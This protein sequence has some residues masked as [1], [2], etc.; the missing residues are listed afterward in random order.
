MGFVLLPVVE[1]VSIGINSAHI[2]VCKIIVLVCK[3]YL[4]TAEQV[5]T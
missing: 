3:D 5:V 2:A 1:L 4:P